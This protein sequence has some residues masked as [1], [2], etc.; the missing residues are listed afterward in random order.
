MT[1]R[2]EEIFLKNKGR[3]DYEISSHISLVNSY[4]FVQVSKAASSN[5]KWALQ[6]LE[7][8]SSPWGVIDVNNKFFSPHLS[9]FQV[10]S[11]KLEEAF[12]LD[13]FKRV[14]FVRN[15]FSRILSCYLHR[16]VA[17]PRSPTN[18]ALKKLTGGRGGPDVPFEEFVELICTQNAVDQE[19]HWRCQA[20]DL[21]VEDIRYDKFGRVEEINKDLP[22][23]IEML[24]GK[25]AADW[26]LNRA[27]SDAS[28][29]K[30]GSSEKVKEF[31][32]NKKTISQIRT[33][34]SLDFEWFGYDESPF[35]S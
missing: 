23:V 21:C 27:A 33:R 15:P 22:D 2:A 8:S 35:R 11:E 5:V 12:F 29:M 19:A 1:N 16:V 32:Q 3:K 4:V 20:E 28:P 34:F 25:K 24:Y 9:P 13:S 30:T 10:P 7:F 18:K 14:A 31:Y 26:Y 6:S 17:K